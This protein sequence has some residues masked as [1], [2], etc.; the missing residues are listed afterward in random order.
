MICVGWVEPTD[1]AIKPD[2]GETHRN[3]SRASAGF[4]KSS[5]HAKN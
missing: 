3:V 4:A 2:R 1:A 5:T